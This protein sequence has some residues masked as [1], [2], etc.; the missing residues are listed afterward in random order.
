MIPD[1]AFALDTLGPGDDQ[2]VSNA[3]IVDDL[4][5]ILERRVPGHGPARVIV[6]IGVGA[7]P[8]VVVL[9]VFLKGRLHAVDH[10]RFVIEAVQS[11]FAAAT[12]VSGEHD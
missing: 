8:F 12:V 9:H 3:A 7:A 10:E 4:F 1:L 11:A 2:R 6:R 5:A